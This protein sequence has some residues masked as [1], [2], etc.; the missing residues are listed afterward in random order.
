MCISGK[1][2]CR[3][4]LPQLFQKTLQS[5][6]SFILETKSVFF[7][8]KNIYIYCVIDEISSGKILYNF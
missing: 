5:V 3:Y 2:I 4:I 7:S 8:N 6:A 1:Y